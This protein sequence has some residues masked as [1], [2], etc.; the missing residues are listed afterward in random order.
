MTAPGVDGQ[1]KNGWRSGFLKSSERAGPG[2]Y[3][4]H[5]YK[6]EVSVELTASTRVGCHRFTFPQTVTAR[7][8]M[9][10]GH[11]LGEGA[12][13]QPY[14]RFSGGLRA[15]MIELEK[16]RLRRL[17]SVC[18]A[19]KLDLQRLESVFWGAICPTKVC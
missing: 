5:L 10:A 11:L 7:V 2:Y 1:D 12:V 15:A 9:D 18:C 8:L 3:R 19:G 16:T 6:H 14:D 17:C 13:F 4:V